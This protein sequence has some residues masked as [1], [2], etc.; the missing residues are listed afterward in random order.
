MEDEDEEEVKVEDEDEDEHKNEDDGKEPRT[1]AQG[2]MVNTSAD[3]IDTLVDNQPIMLPEHGQEMCEHTPHPQP[4]A[5]A[6][7]PQTLEPS[8]GP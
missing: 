4:L 8:P 3:D 7:W 6:L 2:G 1:I 5:P